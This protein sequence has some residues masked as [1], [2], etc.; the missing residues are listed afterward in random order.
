MRTDSRRKYYWLLCVDPDTRKPVL[1]FGGNNEDEARSKGLEMLGGIDFE[2]RALPTRNLQMA[3]AMIRGQ[4]LEDTQSLRKA[5]ER[6][7]H[8]RT[9]DRIRK[10]REEPYE[11]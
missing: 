5:R 9:L 2:I 6:L 1:I 3:S 7:G 4:R 10:R 11:Y 8:D